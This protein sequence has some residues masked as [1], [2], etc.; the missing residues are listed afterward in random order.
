MDDR[1]SIWIILKSSQVTEDTVSQWFRRMTYFVPSKMSGKVTTNSK[2]RKYDAKKLYDGINKEL[3]LTGIVS[4]SVRD[5]ENSFSLI[6]GAYCQ[7][8]TWISFVLRGDVFQQ[9]KINIIDYIDNIMK[10]NDGI[11]ARVCSLVDEFWQDNE[12][13]DYYR[14]KGKSLQGIRT[15]KDELFEGNIIVDT[16]YNPGHSHIVNGI[17]FGSCWMM[18]FGKAYFKYIPIE[19]MENFTNCYENKVCSKDF[20]RITLLK[21][22]T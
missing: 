20:V 7:E 11:V 6:K 10:M 22:R 8:I 5:D 16:E 1:I 9:N 15:K 2:L 14:I 12:D 3:S 19:V 21:L 18:W 17:W 4:I 13:I